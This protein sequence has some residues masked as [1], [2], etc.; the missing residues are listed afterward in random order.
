[1]STRNLDALFSPRSVALIGASNEPGSVGAVIAR[2][3]AAA[4]FGGRLWLVNPHEREILGQAVCANVAALPEGPDLAVIATPPAS[5][6]ALIG[7]LGARGCRAAIV[8]TAGA[9]SMRAEI[10]N[11]ARPFLMRIVGPNCLGFMSPV[12]GLNASFAQFNPARGDIALL[13]QSGAIATSMLDWAHGRSIGFSHIVSLG[14]MSDVDFGDLLDFLALDAA[15]KSILLYVENITHARKF[16]SA[17]RIAARVKPVLVVKAGRGAAGAAAAASHTGALAGADGVYDA[18]FRRAGMLRVESLRDLFDAAT[19]LSSGLKPQGA[20]LTIVTNGGG[21]GVI[22]ADALEELGG[23]L[24][25]LS[26]PLLAALDQCL[27]ATWSH[28]NPIDILGDARAERYRAALSAIDADG[29]QDAV[30]VMNCPTG[31]AD[32]AENADAVIAARGRTPLLACWMSGAPLSAPRRRLLEAKVP[33]YDTPEEA[34]RA[35]MH[36]VDYGRNQRALLETPAAEAEIV[37]DARAKAQGIVAGALADGRSILSEPEAKEVLALYG[38]PVVATAIADDVAEAMRA[39]QAIAAPVALKILSRDITHKSDVGGVALNL[40]TTDAVAEA[41]RAML[42]RVRKARPGARIDGFTVQAMVRCPGAHE[43]ILGLARDPTF[44]PVLMFGHGGVAVEVLADRAI[45][46][47]PLNT[48]LARAMIVRTRV[49]KLLAG[50]R[51][52]PAAQMSAIESA[53]LSLSR[54]AIDLPQISELDINPLLAGASGAIALDARIVVR[55]EAAPPLAIRPYPAELTQSVALD[56]GRALTLRAIRPQDAPALQQMAERTAPE[57]LRL[58]FHGAV[59]GIDA[60]AAAR[61]SQIDYDRE[62]ALVAFE[63]DGAAAGVGR[64]VF[65]PDFEN[66][67]FALIV[68]SDLQHHGLGRALMRAIIDYSRS[69]GALRLWGDVLSENLNMLTLTRA[70]GAATA[71]RP[72][73]PELTRAS[74]AL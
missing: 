58:R 33:T 66:A 67:E 41:A 51:N 17:A 9:A 23:A 63:S 3:L 25:P 36:L 68:R 35:F 59:R 70:M 71:K 10:L 1:M 12:A 37:P 47:P 69:R 31:V 50:Y 64:L 30:L 56:D 57:D 74:F 7:E 16:M 49:A 54:I 46:L 55:D 24:A 39:A 18:A 38:V 34:V 73:A 43:L 4:G 6:P 60:D 14:D 22:A 48:T 27:P 52:R 32:S 20:R 72:E 28:N 45:G 21:L 13:T 42:E 26:G 2:N 40:D 8:I 44:G 62:L 15:T 19:T 11:A 29:D 53:L 65:D 5:V 61:L